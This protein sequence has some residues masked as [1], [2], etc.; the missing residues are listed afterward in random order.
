MF[1]RKVYSILA[2]QLSLTAAF[3]VL[4]Q[5]VP[6]A[7]DFA[8]NNPIL[9]ITCAVLSLVFCIAIVCCFGRV[10][11]TNYILLFLFTLCE[12]YMVGGLTA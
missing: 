6:A 2:C 1:V 7:N 5:T 3:I 4:V 8:L 9:G 10:A 11:P 12:T